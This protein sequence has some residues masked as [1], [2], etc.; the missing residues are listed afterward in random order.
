MQSRFDCVV[1]VI[2][3]GSTDFSRPQF[4]SST[5][6]NELC[7][8]L[9]R[10]RVGQTEL[11]RE[12]DVQGSH[13]S[14]EIVANRPASRPRKHVKRVRRRHGRQVDA[15]DCGNVQGGGEDGARDGNDGTMSGTTTTRT[16]GANCKQDWSTPEQVDTVTGT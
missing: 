14:E 7:N 4:H 6:T 16:G 11:R 8:K 5:S 15:E 9:T 12:E 2:Q 13:D 10:V 3:L 1:S